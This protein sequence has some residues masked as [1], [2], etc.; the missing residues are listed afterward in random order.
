[1]I[2]TPVLAASRILPT[3]MS[4][5]P[6]RSDPLSQ[7]V[8]VVGIHADRLKHNAIPIAVALDPIQLIRIPTAFRR[9][10]EL[11]G[12]VLR[13]VAEV[14]FQILLRSNVVAH[15]TVVVATHV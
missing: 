10:P 5:S 6:S 2:F 3:M 15:H 11:S 8:D 9:F 14:V 1:M 12:N 13:S 4:I 7:L